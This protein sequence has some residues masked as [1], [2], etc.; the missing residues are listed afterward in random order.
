MELRLGMGA[1]P[2]TTSTWCLVADVSIARVVGRGVHRALRGIPF[3]T[4]RRADIHRR[5]LDTTA[6]HQDL[7]PRS[8]M[9]N[10]DGRGRQA[11]GH[12]RR[13]PRD[14]ARGHQ[15]QPVRPGEPGRIAVMTVRYQI[16]QKLHAVTEQPSDRE[17]ARY[18]DLIDLLLLR[19]L[20]EDLSTVR[21]ACTEVFDNRETHPWP[22]ALLVPSSWGEPY[23]VE[24]EKLKFTPAD[25]HEAAAEVKPSSRRSTL[26]QVEADGGIAR[27]NMLV[28]ILCGGPTRARC[29]A[30]GSVAGTLRCPLRCSSGRANRK[31][32]PLSHCSPCRWVSSCC[33]SM[34][35]ASVS[36]R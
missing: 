13:R 20:V 8:R 10:T 21:E 26:R 3:Q 9:A 19:D 18:W 34:P 5:D 30:A 32:C 4:I 14:G 35:S 24:A 15:R 1:R 23:K 2:P 36:M 33:C 11:G 28:A 16:A 7:L 6:A 29:R 22:P 17:N 12:T 25:V 27:A 31:P